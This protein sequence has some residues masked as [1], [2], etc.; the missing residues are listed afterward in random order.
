MNIPIEVYAVTVWVIFGFFNGLLMLWDYYRDCKSKG[1]VIIADVVEMPMVFLLGL[2]GGPIIGLLYLVVFYGDK[3][4]F[5][6][7]NDENEKV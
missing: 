4:V 6:F 5:T 1:Q 3:V 2:V 7:K